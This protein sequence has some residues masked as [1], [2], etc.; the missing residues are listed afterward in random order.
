MTRPLLADLA[1]RPRDRRLP[2]AWFVVGTV[3]GLL[4]ASL[5]GCVVGR[6]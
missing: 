1:R 4:A 3:W 5:V 2:V 6:W